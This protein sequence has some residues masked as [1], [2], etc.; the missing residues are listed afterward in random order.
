M[1]TLTGTLTEERSQKTII[2]ED[3]FK[4]FK[5]VADTGEQIEGALY[6]QKDTFAT[7]GAP[8]SITISNV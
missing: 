8:T 1:A 3:R 6:I 2:Q 4:R 7:F 5:I